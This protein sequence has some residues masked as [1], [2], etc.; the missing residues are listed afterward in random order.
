MTVF[1]VA[2]GGPL[3]GRLS[4]PGDK[5]ISHRVLML[6]ALADGTSQVMGLSD[7]E[8]VAHTLSIVEAL[9]AGVE[10]VDGVVSVTG[11]NLA[12]ADGP[13]YVG[14]SGT[15]IRLLAGM[16]AGLAFTSVLDGDDSIRRRPMDR[17]VDPL[18]SMGADISGV[19]G[20]TLAPL[21]IRGGGLHGT[22]YAPPMASAQ[23]KGCV[24]FAGLFADGPTT[25]VET[26]P[27]RAHT[28]EL[29]AAFGIDV[30]IGPGGVTVQPGMPA[31]FAHRVA[32]DPSQAAF[33]AVAAAIVAESEVL[34]E[35]VYGGPVRTGF[36]DV[37]ARM[38][39]DIEH[40]AVTGDLTVRASSLRGTVVDAAEVPG[41]VD[42]VP[43]LAV[44]AACA[45][46]ET[47]FCGVGELRVKETDRL[48]TTTSELGA[49]GAQVRVEGDDLIVVGG[50]LH[51]AEVE[52]HGDHRIAM[53]CAVAALVAEGPTVVSGWEAVD[54]S[55]PAFGS[56][57]G[58]LR[59]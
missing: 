49:M 1:A 33:W 28:E 30:A 18:Q 52:S 24:L 2:P 10:V 25:V 44:A 20:S 7:G 11:G 47:R 15:G 6:A 39:A 54:T 43:V 16:L 17:V 26:R 4:V 37:L 45:E 51:G 56:D 12:P 42:E 55:Y 50:P 59:S 27:T 53:A 40:D 46:G 38:G 57:L 14:N 41:L 9:G 32:G 3:T 5:S 22:E 58:G 19:D 34:V 29:M 31:P 36:V 13:L 8:D 21:T 23:V 48:A 35:N